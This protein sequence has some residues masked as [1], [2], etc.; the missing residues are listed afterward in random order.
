MT[1][2]KGI[3]FANPGYFWLLLI[4]PAFVGFYIWKEKQLT[5]TLSMP[6]LKGFTLPVKSILP[7]MRY[8]GLALRCL[9]IAALIVAL[10]RPQSS[11]S[12]RNTTTEGIDIMIASDISGSMLAEDFKPNRMEAG[13]QI[14]IDFI[15]ARPD[16]RIGLVIFSGES[17]TQCPLTIDHDVLINLYQEIHNGMIQDGTAIGMGLATAVNRLKDSHVKSKV[18]ILLTDGSNNTGSIPPLTA[19]EIAKQFNIR[20]YTV[21]IGKNGY[22]L[23]PVQTPMGVQ[24]QKLKADIDEVTLKKIADITGG[25]YFRAT[26]NDA[27]KQIY[28]RIDRLE[29]AKIDVT[30]YHKKTELFWPFA[31]VGLFFLLLEFLI[32]NTVLKGAIT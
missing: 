15:K 21:G 10:A 5:G 6:T 17:F 2:F 7:K 3:E 12:W 22:A 9:A 14:A 23:Y 4:I 25:K 20:V 13:K 11:L 31:F 30:Q 29:K 32:R 24:Y 19:A 16:D 18:I 8:A 28:D 26:D 1:W 27:L